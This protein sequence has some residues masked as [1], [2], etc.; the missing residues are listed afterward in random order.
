MGVTSSFCAFDSCVNCLRNCPEL[1]YAGE[2]SEQSLRRKMALFELQTRTFFSTERDPN[3]YITE[4]G[5][6]RAEILLTSEMKDVIRPV[7]SY[8]INNNYYIQVRSSVVISSHDERLLCVQ[9]YVRVLC[10][11]NL[12]RI[13]MEW[14]VVYPSPGN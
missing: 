2:I 12:L 6:T 9:P 1:E 10:E 5:H 14:R 7:Y 8:I 4:N 11:G 3:A 13:F